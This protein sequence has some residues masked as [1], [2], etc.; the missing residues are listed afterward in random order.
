LK[1]PFIL[2]FLLLFVT[3]SLSSGMRALPTVL[4]GGEA[5]A[6]IVNKSNPIN[7]VSLTDLRKIFKAEQTRWSSG[8]RVTV[9]MRQPG[10]DERATA[11]SLIYRMS[12]RD[13]NRYFLRGTFTGETQSVPKTL[14]SAAG[15][16]KF[17]FNVPGAI[18]YVRS[19]EVDDSVKVVRVDGHA[20]Q[21]EGYPLKLQK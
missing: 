6:I 17:I 19:S 2:I 4:P 11:L 7:N 1:A 12:E 5:L 14:A 20:P 21:D 10:Q 13:F 3:L 8:Q 16:G 15:V 18:G 9:V